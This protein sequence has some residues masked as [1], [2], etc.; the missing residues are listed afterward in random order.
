MTP[1]DAHNRM[2]SNVKGQITSSSIFNKSFEMSARNSAT[3][4]YISE[5]RASQLNRYTFRT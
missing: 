3:S 4:I 2:N 5:A 1:S